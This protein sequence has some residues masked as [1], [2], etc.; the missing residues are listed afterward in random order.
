VAIGLRT[1]V[2]QAEA[3][4]RQYGAAAATQVERDE[5][6]TVEDASGRGTK[7]VSRRLLASIIGPRVEEILTMADT[8]VR[9][10]GLLDG[11]SGGVVLSGG[12]SRLSGI[13]LVAEQVFGLPV[14]LGKPDRLTAPR[15]VSQDPSFATAVG[16][17]RCG[18]EGRCVS[19]F[20]E[21]GFW[22]RAG[23]EVKSWFS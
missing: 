2:P 19:C 18:L 15:E 17:V 16:L 14:R 7:Q 9:K 13:E 20:P 3:V 12:G 1:T 23:E 22:S 10:T 11:I 21:P 6:L 4:K 8:E 5:P